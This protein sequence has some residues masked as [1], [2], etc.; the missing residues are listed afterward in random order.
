MTRS[1]GR[2]NNF[3][4]KYGFRLRLYLKGICAIFDKWPGGAPHVNA[5][6]PFLRNPIPMTF[7]SREVFAVPLFLTPPGAGFSRRQLWK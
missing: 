1:H 2:P 6:W 4:K 7:G 3:A 5:V